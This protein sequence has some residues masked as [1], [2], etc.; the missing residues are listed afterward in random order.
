MADGTWSRQN[1]AVTTSLL[2]CITA[3]IITYYYCLSTSSDVGVSQLRVPQ[4]SNSLSQQL[5]AYTDDVRVQMLFA[6][7]ELLLNPVSYENS[8]L[9]LS[10]WVRGLMVYVIELTVRCGFYPRDGCAMHSAAF[11]A[12]TCPSVRLAQP[13]LCLTERKQD[14]E[15]YTI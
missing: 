2:M 6:F 3:L 14:R 1:V 8:V 10:I 5:V 9:R 7:C 11:A 15:M 12:A 4:K 13:V